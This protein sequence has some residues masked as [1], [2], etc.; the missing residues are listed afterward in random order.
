MTSLRRWLMMG[1][2]VITLLLGSCSQGKQPDTIAGDY[3]YAQGTIEVERTSGLQGN[4]GCPVDVAALTQRLYDVNKQSPEARDLLDQGYRVVGR[5]E[6]R[7]EVLSTG[8][9]E[10][11]VYVEASSGF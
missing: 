4:P 10:A 2:A 5:M 7:D 9:E 1:L 3:Y 11:I 6:C 8:L